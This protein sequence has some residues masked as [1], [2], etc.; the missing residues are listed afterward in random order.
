MNEKSGGLDRKANV[1]V[2]FRDAVRECKFSD[3]GSTGHP[4]TWSNRQFGP[5]LIEEKLDRFFCNQEWRVEF[6]DDWATNLV[7]WESDHCPIILDVRER[8]RSLVYERKSFR[9][10]HYEDM[11]IPYEECQNIVK[12]EWFKWNTNMETSPVQKF[13]TIARSSLAQFQSWS[14]REF[15]GRDKK[16]KE[17]LQKLKQAKADGLQYD[18]GREIT[19]IER[20]IQNILIDEETYWKQRSRADWLKGGDKNTKFSMQKHQREKERTRLKVSK[21]AWEIGR[22]TKTR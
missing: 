18:R 21:I 20:Q 19:H 17:L 11:W 4:F 1:I 15:G 13:K 22:M 10:V 2:D 12:S 6:H 16:L 9:R 14:R 7:H 3:L 5:N 8:K